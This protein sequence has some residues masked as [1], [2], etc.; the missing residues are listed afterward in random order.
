MAATVVQR[1]VVE[2]R[3][4]DVARERV[5]DLFCAHGLEPHGDVDL[6]LDARRADRVGI[7]EMDYG[8]TVDIT[9]DPLDSFYLVQIPQRGAARIDHEGTEIRSDPSVA[10]VLSPRSS[11]SMTWFAGNPQ[12]V[13]YLDRGLVEDCARS[14]TGRASD[15]PLIF[16]V[17]MPLTSPSAHSWLET[18]SCLKAELTGWRSDTPGAHASALG[19]S[20]AAQ[21]IE[22]QRH[23]FTDVMARRASAARGTAR[24]AAQ[25]IEENLSEPLT[26]A[27]VAA[28]QGVCTRVLQ[29]AFRR[30]LDTTPLTYIRDLRM[31]TARARLLAGHPDELSVTDVALG[32]GMTHLGR[33]SVDYRR[34]FGES[35]SHTLRIA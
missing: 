18:V 19:R 32:V 4:V 17:G 16:D 21:L 8:A 6:R 1:D 28:E 34:R 13:V 29:E 3:H 2:T 12:T 25:Y 31:R 35:P 5:A 11:S 26:V 15:E 7:V 22:T 20:V 14:L 10:S 24:R 33:F 27:A 23:N 9:P 30:E